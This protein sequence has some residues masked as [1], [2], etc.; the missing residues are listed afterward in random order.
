MIAARTNPKYLSAWR[1]FQSPFD[2]RTSSELGDATTP[3]SY[4]IN[5]NIYPGGI[6]MSADKITKPTAFILFAPAQ[7]SSATVNF[8]GN[9]TTAAPG[10]T[11]LGNANT[12]TS[13]PGGMATG[14]THNNR[15]RINA[16]FA[17]LHCENYALDERSAFTRHR[18]AKRPG[19]GIPLDPVHSVSDSSVRNSWLRASLPG[20]GRLGSCSSNSANAC[21]KHLRWQEH[22]QLFRIAMLRRS[23]PIESNEV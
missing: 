13:T 7:N 3:I 16:L 9:A 6:A 23:S 11:L 21:R 17:D 20:A 14:G 1:I 12:V 15:R 18:S 5:A 22:A 10:V 19:R 8:Q 4:G 2:K